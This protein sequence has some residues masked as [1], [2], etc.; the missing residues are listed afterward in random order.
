MGLAE[1]YENSKEIKVPSVCPSCGQ[2]LTQK[3]PLLFCTNYDGCKEQ[4]I[5]R[6][7]HFASRDAFN[8]EGLSEKTVDAFYENL[9]VREISDLYNLEKEKILNLDKFKDKKTENILKSIEKSKNIELYRFLYALGISE[10]GVKT[11]KDIA[12]YFGTFE[13]LKKATFEEILKVDEIGDIIANNIIEFF[14]N[15][16]NLQEIQ[17]LFDSGVTIK[18]NV[19]TQKN[20]NFDGKTFVIT[21]TLSKPR[22]EFE[23]MIENGG[24]KVS[25]SVSK[26]T[27]FV[28]VGQDAG[29]KLDKAKTLG[30]K[31]L[32]EEEF[33]K[34]L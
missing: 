31:I 22:K 4:I 10:V 21:G 14:N 25:S 28:L 16:K 17:K 19:A 6:L 2:P 3:G 27:D 32:T 29:S 18:E 9:G 15:E 30:I 24:G 12:K 26:N 5:D 13:N 11:A 23:Q 33:L 34:M 7:S 1:K 20:D 8:I